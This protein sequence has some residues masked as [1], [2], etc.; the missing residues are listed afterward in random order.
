MRR[1]IINRRCW[2]CGDLV[3]K[4]PDKELMMQPHP[5]NAEFVVTHLG[6]KQYF[7]TKCWYGMIEEQ[8]QNRREKVNA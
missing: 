1:I 5:Y 8:K 2:I 4:V 3:D 7:H 6:R